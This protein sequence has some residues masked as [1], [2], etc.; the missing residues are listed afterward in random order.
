MGNDR[1]LT[2]K[3]MLA[4]LSTN[5]K[6]HFLYTQRARIRLLLSIAHLDNKIKQAGIDDIAAMRQGFNTQPAALQQ[7]QADITQK[8]QGLDAAVAAAK[9]G[10]A[11]NESLK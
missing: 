10:L 11:D 7:M 1:D 2:A 9:A 8:H 5:G 6:Y 4:K 3:K